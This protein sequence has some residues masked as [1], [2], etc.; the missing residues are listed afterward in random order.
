MHFTLLLLVGLLITSSFN[1]K[2][3]GIEISPEMQAKIKRMQPEF[4]DRALIFQ[5]TGMTK[6][7]KLNTD[8]EA[9]WAIFIKHISQTSDFKNKTEA[10]IKKHFANADPNRI[11]MCA[12]QKGEHVLVTLPRKK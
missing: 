8:N 2:S 5:Q 11:Y 4:E 10:E 12:N 1:I 9:N 3:N 6:C 7:T